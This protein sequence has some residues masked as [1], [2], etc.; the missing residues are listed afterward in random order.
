MRLLRTS[1][2]LELAIGDTK[3]ILSPL[4]KAQMA[5]VQENVKIVN[6]EAVFDTI[7]T[8]FAS[9]KYSIKDVIGVTTMDGE[10]YKVEFA[11]EAKT[12]LTDQCTE[13]LLNLECQT[14][15]L[16]GISSMRAGKFGQV[17]DHLNQPVEGVSLEYKSGQK[18]A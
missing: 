1:D 15:L 8:A 10:P 17:R 7:Q 4:T 11:D 2:R 5:K 13:D 9:F 18:K 12:E 6:G 3:F 16:Q 14:Q